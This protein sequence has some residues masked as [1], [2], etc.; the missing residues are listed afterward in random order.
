MTPREIAGQPLLYSGSRLRARAFL[1]QA[2]DARRVQHDLLLARVARHADGQFG[3]DHHFGEIRSP[4]DFRKRVP[5]SGYDRH[6]P[7]IDQASGRATWAP[8][9][10]PAPRS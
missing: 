8:C 9:S 6:E 4:A 2:R 10:G 7:Y 5:V 1:H 3:R